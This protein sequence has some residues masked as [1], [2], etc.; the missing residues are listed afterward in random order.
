MYKCRE[1]GCEQSYKEM[2][3][4]SND[5]CDY[6]Y[7]CKQCGD[8]MESNGNSYCD[9]VNNVPNEIHERYK[10]KSFF[11]IK[12]GLANNNILLIKWN[13]V[14]DKDQNNI[15]VL[16]TRYIL[17]DS[18]NNRLSLK[19]LNLKQ[20][21]EFKQIPITNTMTEE[22]IDCMEET[23]DKELLIYSRFG[24]WI[25]TTFQQMINSGDTTITYMETTNEE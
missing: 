20:P 19:I 17:F 10:D 8:V 21:V 9:L 5:D 13:V 11:T 3:Y 2:R 14:K 24:E 6:S 23:R 18:D 16:R 4:D 22:L 25:N 15:L 1:C 7:Y 12:V